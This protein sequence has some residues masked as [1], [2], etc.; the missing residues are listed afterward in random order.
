MVDSAHPSE[1]R[2][3]VSGFNNLLRSDYLDVQDQATAIWAA[4]KLILKALAQ[5]KVLLERPECSI[6]GFP[7]LCQ[8]KL[9]SIR[10]LRVVRETGEAFADYMDKK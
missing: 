3:A 4:K 5:W 1:I 7:K 2:Y 6:A 9:E 10:L 8:T